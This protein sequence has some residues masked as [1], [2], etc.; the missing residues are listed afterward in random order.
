VYAAGKFTYD[1]TTKKFLISFDGTTGLEVITYTAPQALK[2]VT[3]AHGVVYAGGSKLYAFPVTGGARIGT[4]D[5]TTAQTRD[6]GGHVRPAAFRDLQVEGGHLYAACQC[7]QLLLSNGS[8][9]L[10]KA[11]VRF[12][13][14]TG[15][16]DPTWTPYAD[17]PDTAAFGLGIDVMGG[18]WCTPRSVGPTSR[19]RSAR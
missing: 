5:T 13:R 9:V 8:T 17:R 19:L 14:V 1:N 18:V 16:W 12:D 3:V 4:F 6:I 10:T 7:D 2:S 15:A 11:L